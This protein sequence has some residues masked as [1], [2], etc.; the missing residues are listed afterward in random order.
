MENFVELT[1]RLLE[2]QSGG[3]QRSPELIAEDE[4]LID[5]LQKRTL[6]GK[7]PQRVRLSQDSPGETR[8]KA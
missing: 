3:R 6:A 5:R 7:P 4:R 2:I 1:Q 8:L